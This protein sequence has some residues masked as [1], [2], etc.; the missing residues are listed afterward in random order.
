MQTYAHRTPVARPPLPRSASSAVHHSDTPQ[1]HRSLARSTTSTQILPRSIYLL[2][3]IWLRTRPEYHTELRAAW[4]GQDD[5]LAVSGQPQCHSGRFAAHWNP[6]DLGVHETSNT[7][8]PRPGRQSFC[9]SSRPSRASGP[10]D[11]DQAPPNARLSK[12]LRRQTPDVRLADGHSRGTARSP[13]N[14][15]VILLPTR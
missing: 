2:R 11:P 5:H 3:S 8:C 10:E 7:M 9:R 13:R 12:H 6:A 1:A 14:S 4:Q 15:S